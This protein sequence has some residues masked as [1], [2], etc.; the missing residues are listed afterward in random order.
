MRPERQTGSGQGLHMM[1][2]P[3]IKHLLL[4]VRKWF[5]CFMDVVP[6]PTITPQGG[7]CSLPTD[8]TVQGG[9]VCSVPGTQHECE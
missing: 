5:R 3:F 9:E 1:S 7:N 4:R 8:V 6:I 2:Q